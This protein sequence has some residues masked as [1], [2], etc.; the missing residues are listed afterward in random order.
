MFFN[1]LHGIHD[2]HSLL[3]LSNVIN[4]LSLPEKKR[5]KH[6]NYQDSKLT[7]ILQP[8]LS[9]NAEMA[10]ICC[11]SAYK[12]SLEEARAT[13][14]FG[15]RAKLVTVAPTVNELND[16]S[17]LVKKLHQELESLKQELERYKKEG[18]PED[19]RIRN[20][21]AQIK[22]KVPGTSAPAAQTS[23]LSTGSE[24]FD[25]DDVSYGYDDMDAGP[26]HREFDF[27]SNQEMPPPE[28]GLDDEGNKPPA[29]GGRTY[30][31]P[32]TTEIPEELQR[33]YEMPKDDFGAESKREYVMPKNHELNE[34][35]LDL[36]K[37]FGDEDEP[38]R[39]QRGYDDQDSAQDMDRLLSGRVGEAD[40]E[41]EESDEE[42]DDLHNSA[43]FKLN[44]DDE[45]DKLQTGTSYGSEDEA[46]YELERKDSKSKPHS[47]DSDKNG[48]RHDQ[49]GPT[50][51]E[52]MEMDGPERSYAGLSEKFGSV[53]SKPDTLRGASTAGGRSKYGSIGSV[54]N[55]NGRGGHQVSWDT[56][57]L[58]TLQK[59]QAGRPLKAIQSLYHREAPIPEEIT[60]MQVAIF[61]DNVDHM[62]LTDKLNDAEARS[63][64]MQ[65]R[66]EMADDLVEGIFKDLERA[67]LCIHDL[68]YRNSQLSAKLKEKKREDVKEEY[69]ETE[70]VVEQYWLLKGAM[71]VGLFFFFSGGYEFF[72]ASVFLVWLILEIN[73]GSLT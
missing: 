43:A 60:I 7:R 8:H 15:S 32:K 46:L 11:A 47:L 20:A 28:A 59:E 21:P 40:S 13:F 66:L 25:D 35:P 52:T 71:Y 65:S 31:M 37:E 29:M 14:Q 9:G 70:V 48:S 6:I 63:T 73:L 57:D 26:G 1:I 36:G 30:V 33:D 17:A 4:N 53:M 64:F 49:T 44:F 69:Q 61:E 67:R 50:A 16:D 19:Q 5:P 27:V 22:I 58:N 12:A 23:H 24:D 34:I 42:L 41:A 55:F 72:M 38:G 68:V 10:I 2:D 18:V 51:D 54:D 56:M 62:C 3:S 39:N 45:D